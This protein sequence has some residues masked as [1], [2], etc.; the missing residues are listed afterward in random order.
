MAKQTSSYGRRCSSFCACLLVFVV[1]VAAGIF[2][3]VRLTGADSAAD[4]LPKDFIP[5]L[6]HFFAED[7]YNA[8]SPA[9]ANRWQGFTTGHGGLELEIVNSLDSD[10][11][12]FFNIAV[13][14]WDEGTPDAL[15]LSVSYDTPG[16]DCE[17][18]QGKMRVCNGDYGD[19]QWE[20]INT[21]LTEFDRIVWSSAKMNEYYLKKASE[22]KRQYTMC[23]EVSY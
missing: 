20:G 23:H 22:E 8:T 11:H 2:L 3:A 9:D 15:T 16:A 4:L 21:V 14:E 1:I 6:D 12:P 13:Q 10:W 17:P 18:I 7:P 5:T 19:T